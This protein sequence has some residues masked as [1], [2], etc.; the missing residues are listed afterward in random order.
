MLKVKVRFFA[1][2]FKFSSHAVGLIE[3]SLVSLKKR[4]V[5]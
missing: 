5:H 4:Q 1:R 3:N 2:T